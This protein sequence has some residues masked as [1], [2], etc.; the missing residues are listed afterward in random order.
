MAP[1]FAAL[2][3]WLVVRPFLCVPTSLNLDSIST[4]AYSH[5]ACHASLYL[6]SPLAP[7]DFADSRSKRLR[8]ALSHS[9]EALCGVGCQTALSPLSIKYFSS[10]VYTDPAAERAY[11][12]SAFTIRIDPSRPTDL[13]NADASWIQWRSLR[14]AN[15][16][17]SPSLP[18]PPP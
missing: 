13:Q 1:H 15:A 11:S 8:N 4:S 18:N 12:L 10:I 5:D 16:P 3:T 7:L 17:T 14:N 9:Y 6:Q 2:L